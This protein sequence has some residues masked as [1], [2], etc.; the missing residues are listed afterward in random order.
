[1]L[2]RIISNRRNLEHILD[3]LK[4]G[5]IAHDLNRM[6]FF[7]NREAEKITGFTREEVLGRDCHEV[8]GCPLCG[9]RCSFCGDKPMPEQRQEYAVSICTK[10][11]EPRRI[12]MTVSL[13]RDSGDSVI[14][15]LAS[16][17]DVSDILELQIRAGKLE[18]FS[19]I[20]GRDAN[21]QRIFKQI[22]DLSGYNYP[23]H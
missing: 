15:V 2:E 3:N 20:I 19:G 5:I 7:F 8:F 12:D 4:E 21:M 6:I 13:M 10:T 23:I 11:G 9:E 14:G 18:R 1:M 17:N 22:R 16:F